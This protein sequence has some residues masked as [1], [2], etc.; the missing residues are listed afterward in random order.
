MHFKSH[1]RLLLSLPFLLAAEPVT[2]LPH[3]HCEVTSL[4]LSVASKPCSRVGSELHRNS[5]T[6]TTNKRQP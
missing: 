5:T 1:M 2:L 6:T 4:S 3:Q